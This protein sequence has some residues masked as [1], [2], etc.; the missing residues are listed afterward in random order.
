MWFFLICLITGTLCGKSKSQAEVSWEDELGGLI[1]TSF[2]LQ[3]KIT[4]NKGEVNDIY[5]T[6]KGKNRLSPNLF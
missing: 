6:A 5:E 4:L 3:T 1:G 2:E